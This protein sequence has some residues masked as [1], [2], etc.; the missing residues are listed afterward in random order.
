MKKTSFFAFSFLFCITVLS[1]E[2]IPFIDYNEISEKATEVSQTND[3]GK[4]I[5]LLNKVNKNDSVYSNVLVSKTY[6]LLNSKKYEEAIK[7]ANEGLKLNNYDS[8]ASFYVNKGLAHVYQEKYEEA[9]GIYNK[10]IETYPKYYLL[11]YNKGAVLEKLNRVEEAIEAYQKVITYNPTYASPHLQLGN[12]CYKQ[13]LMTQAM[14]CYNIYLLLKF[15]EESAFNTLKSLNNLVA[16]KNDNKANPDI[17][18]SADD[19]SFEDIDLVLSNK[20]ALN[21]NYDSGNKISISLTNQNHAMITQLEGFV[22]NGGFWDGKYV[23]LFNWIRENN[24]FDSFTYTLSYSI[25]NEKFKKIIN[26]NEKE[27]IS[28]VEL[29]YEKWYDI[30]KNNTILFDEKKQ[31]VEYNYYN[32]YTE[33][34]GKMINGISIGNWEFYNAN[35][36]LTSYGAYN[37]TG[38]RAGK[39]TWLYNNG[40]VKEIAVYDAGILNGENIEYFPNEKPSIIANYVNGELDGEY[41]YYN[42]KGAL[43]QKKY[44]KN[45]ELEG[46]YTSYFEVGKNLPEYHIPYKQGAVDIGFTEYYANGNVYAE[47]PFANGKREG[48][49][50]KYLFNKKISSEISYKNGELNGT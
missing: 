34:I 27:I 11:W 4:V 29:F 17:Q 49:E 19:I 24:L 45:G 37:D 20:I 16:E 40:K 15:D 1:Q 33:A 18:V 9:L 46:L 48:I 31:D 41:K 21:K 2:K 47:V 39:W 50:K 22:G 8:N 28:F 5:E 26:Q 12:I 42:N 10:G 25:E 7:V 6:Y 44:F 43:L 38:E 36:Q 3:Y 30:L 23:P 35:G 14:M 13:E 32:G